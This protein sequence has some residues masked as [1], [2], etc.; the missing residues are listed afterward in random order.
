VEPWIGE[1]AGGGEFNTVI[2]FDGEGADGGMIV[3][4]WI[5]EAAGGG[6]FSTVIPFEGGSAGGGLFLP[7]VAPIGGSAGGGSFT[8]ASAGPSRVCDTGYVPPSTVVAR[9]VF[10]EGDDSSFDGREET[11]DTSTLSLF[12]YHDPQWQG[13]V[14]HF[15]DL[16]R[17]LYLAC[18]SGTSPDLMTIWTDFTSIYDVAGPGVPSGADPLP[19][20]Y[21]MWLTNLGGDL[22]SLYEITISAT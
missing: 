22:F 8:A 2:P 6:E 15:Y 1:A 12:G 20:V 13:D 14:F 7:G 16:D 10:M 19:I 17:Y 4:P 18:A 21:E 11:L 9:W 3:E 5:G